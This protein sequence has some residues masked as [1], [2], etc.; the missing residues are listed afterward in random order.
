MPL[1][2]LL[3]MPIQNLLTCITP[4]SLRIYYPYPKQG[5][6]IGSYLYDLFDNFNINY[7]EG[8]VFWEVWQGKN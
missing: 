4:G 7:R 5:V 6:I 3:L 8:K 1:Q 2:G